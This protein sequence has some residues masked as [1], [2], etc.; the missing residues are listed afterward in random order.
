VNVRLCDSSEAGNYGQRQENSNKTSTDGRVLSVDITNGGI[1]QRS[2]FSHSYR[3]IKYVA[4]LRFRYQCGSAAVQVRVWL[5][6]FSGASVAVLR[7]RCECGCSAFQVRVWLCCGSVASVPVLCFRCVCGCATVQV[8]V[9]LCCGSGASVAVLR[10]SCECG[11]AAVQVPV[12]VLPPAA[13]SFVG[14]IGN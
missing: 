14:E 11:C 10:F 4:V 6:C 12:G 3:V 8:R 5:C 13:V 9:W 2:L 1:F 7:F